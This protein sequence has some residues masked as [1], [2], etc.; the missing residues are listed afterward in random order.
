M[1]KTK[2]LS[3]FLSISLGANFW[4]IW[5]WYEKNSLLSATHLSKPLQVQTLP[6]AQWTQGASKY[7]SSLDDAGYISS[8]DVSSS[9][10][11]AH[12]RAQL[13]QVLQSLSAQQNF[14]VLAYEVQDY[15]RMYPNHVEALLLEAQAYFHTKPLNQAIVHYQSLLSLPL[16]KN[17]RNQILKLIEVNTSRVIQQFTG[18]AAWDLLAKFLEPLVQI[19][20][21]N[22]QYLLGLARAYGM[23]GQHSL[24]ENVL[25]GLAPNDPRAQRLREQIAAR[26]NGLNDSNDDK[27]ASNVNTSLSDMLGSEDIAQSMPDLTLQQ[28]RGQ[29]ISQAN[30]KHV[31]LSLLLDTGAST[32]AI[33]DTKFEQIPLSEVEFLG[34]FTVNTAGG[35]IQAPIYKIKHF[36]LGNHTL[37]NTSVLILP[38]N[39]LSSF[40]G[41]LGMNIL[42]Q[43]DLSFDAE[44]ET[45]KMYKK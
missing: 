30:I 2:W 3:F 9:E 15:L 24:M 18:D 25:A 11:Q 13:F 43:F 26:L 10:T 16:D 44:S 23:Q 22:R 37:N 36:Q 40:D 42:S 1:Y 33:S 38:S 8:E 29:F 28:S 27:L 41:L 31:E 17:Q 14:E 21:L 32:T 45:V 35:S 7:S 4:F 6:Q 20:P 39:N 5:K 12:D 34:Q 19:D